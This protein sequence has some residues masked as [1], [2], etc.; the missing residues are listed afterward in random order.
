MKIFYVLGYADAEELDY[1]P[2]LHPT[3]EGDC[4]YF[5]GTNLLSSKMDKA[6]VTY[7]EFI[8]GDLYLGVSENL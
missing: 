7:F 8:D 3:E 1:L 6:F 4:Y 5:Y 2:M